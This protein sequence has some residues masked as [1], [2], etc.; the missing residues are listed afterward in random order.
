MPKRVEAVRSY[1]RV[2]RARLDRTCELA[3]GVALALALNPGLFRQCQPPHPV[4]GDE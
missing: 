2:F 3:L 1:D 4:E